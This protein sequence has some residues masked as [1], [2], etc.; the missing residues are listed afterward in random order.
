MDLKSKIRVIEGF[1]SPEIS[2]KDITTLLRD[3]EAL[4]ETVKAFAARLRD[5]NVDYIAAPE[6]RGFILGA[7]VA[8]ELGVG[9][10][11]VRKSGKLPCVVVSYTYD[12][13]YGAD[14]L[15]IDEDALEEGDR[16]AIVDDLLATGGTAQ[17]VAHLIESVGAQV[18]SMDFLIELKDLEGRKKL[19]GYEV[20]ALVAY[21]K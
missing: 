17:A 3:G 11:L 15:E 6:A 14:T 13:E 2:F 7:A 5:K 19:D 21:D 1:P 10:V 16:V 4:R 12:L 20:H 9:L 8:Y 18:V